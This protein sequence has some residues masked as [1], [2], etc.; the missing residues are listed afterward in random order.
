MAEV[1]PFKGVRYNPDLISDMADIVAPPYD[2]ISPKEQD[3]FHQRHPNNVIRLI[4]ESPG[5]KTTSRITSIPAPDVTLI[6]GVGKR[7]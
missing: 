7:C 5:L 2:A 3:G 4:L 1:V 6:I